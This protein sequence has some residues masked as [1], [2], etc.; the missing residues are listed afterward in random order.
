M[1]GYATEESF[2]KMKKRDEL[3]DQW[4]NSLEILDM[5]IVT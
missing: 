3:T 1:G 2:E 4:Y 5:D